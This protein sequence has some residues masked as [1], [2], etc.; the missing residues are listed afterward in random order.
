MARIETL[1][2]LRRLQFAHPCQL[3]ALPGNLERR[4]GTP[5]LECSGG[6]LIH[7]SGRVYVALDPGGNLSGWQRLGWFDK[8]TRRA[9][10]AQHRPGPLRRRRRRGTAQPPGCSLLGSGPRRAHRVSFVSTLH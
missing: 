9:R 2:A 8:R 6:R 3:H 7:P 5:Y 4:P 10:A 1:P